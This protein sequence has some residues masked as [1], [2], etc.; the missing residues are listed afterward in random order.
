MYSYEEQKAKMFTDEGQRKLLI[1]RDTVRKLL[2][3]AGAFRMDKAWS[4][5]GTYD[6]WEALAYVD[7]L[8]ELNEI[9]EVTRSSRAAQYRV[10]E[11]A[12]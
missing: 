2:E 1:V 8:V 4:R 6:S 10:F 7:R 11:S 12:K 9:H 5:L 3:D